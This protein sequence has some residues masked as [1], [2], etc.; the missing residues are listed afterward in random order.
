MTERNGINLNELNGVNGHHQDE[1]APLSALTIHHKR[2]AFSDK[3]LYRVYSSPDHFKLVEADSAYEAYQNADVARPFKIEQETFYRYL[4]LKPDQL[5]DGGSDAVQTD[6]ELPDEEEM[7]TLLFAALDESGEGESHEVPFEEI[8]ITD[9]QA[10]SKSEVALQQP[11]PAPR[12][13]QPPKAQTKP[14]PKSEPKAEAKPEAKPEAR[15]E[16]MAPP[17]EPAPQASPEAPPP[18]QDAPQPA[19]RPVQEGLS[20]EEVEALLNGK[21][22]M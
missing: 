6:P 21:A 11:A 10:E 1:H 14:E 12:P 17:P 3:P 2:F 19:A 13:A 8:M 4:V 22:D 7:K 20:P 5:E 9:L 18:V 15:E 16:P